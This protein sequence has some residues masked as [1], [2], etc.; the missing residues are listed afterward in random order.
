MAEQP[1]AV[2]A[3]LDAIPAKVAIKS[4]RAAKGAAQT[5]IPSKLTVN[6]LRFPKSVA[7]AVRAAVTEA[8]LTV[9]EAGPAGE[10]ASG[11]GDDPDAPLIV[12]INSKSGGRLGPELFDALITE[13]GPLQVY[14]LSKVKPQV[15]LETIFGC[16]ERLAEQGDESAANTRQRLRIVTAGGD[17]TVGWLLSVLEKFPSPPPVAVIPLGT[18]NDLSRTFGWGPAFSFLGIALFEKQLLEVV[19]A[20]P[21]KLDGWSVQV[22]PSPD[23]DTTQMHLPYALHPQKAAEE[24]APTSFQGNFYLYFSIGMDAQVA[25]SFHTLRERKPW[26]ARGRMANQ[27]IYGSYGC[28]QGWFCTCCAVEPQARCVHMIA[29]FSVQRTKDGPWEDLDL[30]T[31]LRAVVVLNLPSYAGGRN[32]WGKPSAELNAKEG[33]SPARPDD[34]ML[35]VIGLRGGWHTMAVMSNMVRGDRIAQ[36]HGMRIDLRGE[37][38][39]LAYMQIDGEPWEQPL[40]VDSREPTHVELVARPVQSDMVAPPNCRLFADEGAAA[41]VGAPAAAAAAAAADGGADGAAAVAE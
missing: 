9:P 25:H 38:R 20:R 2:G 27:A 15:A 37:H 11:E 18:G 41:A 29:T 24:A 6:S 10:V 36:V 7:A 17:G 12:F 34:G 40:S 35:E 4:L 32:P 19:S 28:T 30:P 39:R 14:D 5:I 13:I 21:C 16:L 23:M 1:T 8:K 26:L 3:T 31:N 22:T 33:W